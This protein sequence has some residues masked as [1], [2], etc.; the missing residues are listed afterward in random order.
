MSERCL[1]LYSRRGPW[2]N[3]RDTRGVE[4]LTIDQWRGLSVYAIA[5]DGMADRGEVDADLMRASGLRASLQQRHAAE[6][7][8]DSVRRC[9][10]T[11]AIDDGHALSVSGIARDR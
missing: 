2:M 7:L 6:P 4:K 11:A 3:E 9:G 5:N 10:V 1:E 8:N